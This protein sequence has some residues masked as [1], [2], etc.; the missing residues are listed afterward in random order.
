[1]KIFKISFFVLSFLEVSVVNAQAEQSTP[2]V[3]KENNTK[4]LSTSTSLKPKA[5]EAKQMRTE[6]KKVEV[7]PV[8]NIGNEPKQVNPELSKE[9]E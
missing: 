1:M 4:E 9:E 7:V 2:A 5:V 3:E 6:V 8:E